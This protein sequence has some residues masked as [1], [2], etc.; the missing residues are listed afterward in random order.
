MSRKIVPKR[1]HRVKRV[2][3]KFFALRDSLGRFKRKPLSKKRGKSL[4]KKGKLPRN[5]YRF[6]RVEDYPKVSKTHHDVYSIYPDCDAIAAVFDLY[7]KEVKRNQYAYHG[8]IVIKFPDKISASTKSRFIR[9]KDLPKWCAELDRL[10][11]SMKARFLDNNED[12]ELDIKSV[13]F[14]VHIVSAY[15][16]SNV[17]TRKTGKGNRKKV[18]HTRHRKQTRRKRVSGKRSIKKRKR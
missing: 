12:V 4:S 3:R 18:R 2:K 1:D 15:K 9:Q 14:E 6:D 13:K 5:L 10:F 11:R 16:V 17:K 7:K 8:F